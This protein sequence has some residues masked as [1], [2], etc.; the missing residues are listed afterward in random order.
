ME[1]ETMPNSK[2]GLANASPE[3]RRRVAKMGA[4]ARN[5]KRRSNSGGTQEQI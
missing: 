4:E 5:A 2:R 3:T 1:V